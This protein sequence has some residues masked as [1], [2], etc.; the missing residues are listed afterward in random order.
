MTTDK[1]LDHVVPRLGSFQL[2]VAIGYAQKCRYKRLVRYLFW[3]VQHGL[4]RADCLSRPPQSE[5]QPPTQKSPLFSFCQR[6]RLDVVQNAPCVG[7]VSFG[8]VQFCQAQLRSR[9]PFSVVNK[10]REFCH[11]FI[12]PFQCAQCLCRSKGRCC[13]KLESSLRCQ[14]FIEREGVGPAMQ[15]CK[16]LGAPKL[17]P[18]KFA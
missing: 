6:L 16:R 9:S 4:K 12:R 15:T 14:L 3:F 13:A 5:L 1:L 2:Q 11:C 17:C 10:L 18:F 8:D 7:C